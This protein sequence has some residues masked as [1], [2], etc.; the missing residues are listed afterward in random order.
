[1]RKKAG[2]ESVDA[3]LPQFIG[4][5]KYKKKYYEQLVICRWEKIVG[6]DIARHVKAA[7]FDFNTLFLMSDSPVWS[8]QLTMMKDELITKINAFAGTKIVKDLRFTQGS[9]TSKKVDIGGE[10]ISA[11]RKVQPT[12]QE[13]RQAAT[14]CENI[15]DDELRSAVGRAMAASL[16]RKRDNIEKGWHKCEQCGTLCVPTEKFCNNCKRQERRTREKKIREILTACPW[17]TYAEIYNHVHCTAREANEQRAI[18][19]QRLAG[20]VTYGDKT[21]LD[22]KMLTMLA[23]SIP[24]EKLTE[25]HIYR[26]VKRFRWMMQQPENNAK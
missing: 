16:A 8:N 21:S 3:L 6:A 14:A 4:S 20:K 13:E 23:D 18:M 1:M 12:E 19:L 2:I 26:V 15:V 25:E 7:R 24:Y 22:V 17:S 9:D 5:M 10:K 11:E